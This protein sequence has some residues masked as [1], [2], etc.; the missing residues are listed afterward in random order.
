L[1]KPFVFLLILLPLISGL[2]LAPAIVRPAHATGLVG[3]VCIARTSDTI[4]PQTAPTI[5]GPTSPGPGVQFRFSILVNASATLNGFDITLLTNR[6]VLLPTGVSTTNSVLQGQLTILAKCIGGVGI[7]CTS[8]DNASTLHFSA[9][10]GTGQFTTPPTTGLLF[11]A[12][13]NVT[14]LSANTPVTFQTGCG[15]TSAG[16]GVCVT[17]SNG[18]TNN[19]PETSLTA[20]FS[21]A[22]NGYFD[23]EGNT[24]NLQISQG[25]VDSS[26]FIT[27]TSLNN[28]GGLT[29]STVNLSGSS[30]PSGPIVT[31]SPSS[32]SLT[33]G[34]P[35]NE[36]I[37]GITVNVT[38]NVPVGNYTLSI[39]GTSGSLPPNTIAIHLVVPK[40]D[41]MITPTPNAVNFNVTV[42]GTSNIVISSIGNYAANVTVSATTSSPS[43]LAHFSNNQQQIQLRLHKGSTNTTLLTLNSTIAGS[44]SV[45]VTSISGPLF[46]FALISVHVLDYA[47]SVNDASALT[48]LNGTTTV[49]SINIDAS[50]VYNVTVT[51]GT[52]YVDQVTNMI[53][54]PSNGVK[55][56][57]SPLNLKLVYTGNTNG[58]NTTNCQV[59]GQAIGNYVVTVTATSGIPGRSSNHALSFLVSVIKPNFSI[60]I[61]PTL[62][63]VSVGSSVSIPV[64]FAA[65]NGLN[66]TVT[67]NLSLTNTNL[68]PVP[69]FS[70][71]ISS[72]GKLYLTPSSPNSTL[73]VTITTSATTATGFYTLIID[74][75]GIKSN[76]TEVRIPLQFL[77]VSTTSPHNLS[78]YSVT[79]STTSTTVGSDVTIT[80]LVQ[81]LGRVPENATIV[82]IVGDQTIGT[83]NATI[84]VGGNVTETFVWHTTSYNPGA[85]MVGGKVIGYD[86]LRS[87][88]PVT[89][90]AANTSILANPYTL[91]A[92][93][94]AAIILVL[95]ALAIFYFVP[96]RKIQT[97]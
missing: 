20:K 57:C 19:V 78:V 32:V 35:N 76:P 39:T 37:A 42:Q 93:I 91:P 68:S 24:G 21:N 31:I 38:S 66:D 25:D 58:H 56:G 34:L 49:K 81:N 9:Q 46:H 53:N 1:K 6:T 73:L 54:S 65:N 15:S 83:K 33:G 36:T 2:Y 95:A 92:I 50:A 84:A 11:T 45:N 28:F 22:V 59:T 40:P 96:K 62:T 47:L 48:V 12:I 14:A 51:I 89:L 44:Y 87:A 3:E 70:S 72:N 7:G 18:S 61:P 29:G 17:I 4:C 10:A 26:P 55:V 88:T 41:F 63:V 77:V 30:S 90:N 94:I 23:I 80:I 5:A 86:T 82:G 79:S 67:V 69:G 85:Y 71:N 60:L 43:L 74:G 97:S 13:Y 52:V 16:N 8:N 64:K 75:S 27:I